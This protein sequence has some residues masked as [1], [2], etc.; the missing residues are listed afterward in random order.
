M[1]AFW[2]ALAFADVDLPDPLTWGIVKGLLLRHFRWW[3]NYPEIFGPSGCLTIGYTYPN[4]HMI[5]NYGSPGSPYWACL[6]FVCL[7]VPEEHPLWASEEEPYPSAALLKVKAVKHP[8]HIIVR[9]GGHSFLLSRYM[10]LFR[11]T[12]S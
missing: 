11:S 3:Q 8:G 2:S 6:A 10:A 7:A 4:M 5:E 1:I 12:S 9:E